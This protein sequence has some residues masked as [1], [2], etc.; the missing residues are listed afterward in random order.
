MYTEQADV[1]D[2]VVPSDR[3][4]QYGSFGVKGRE[5][6]SVPCYVQPAVPKLSGADGGPA[7]VAMVLSSR[8]SRVEPTVYD[9]QEF[10]SSYIRSAAP[11]MNGP[12]SGEDL[13][14]LLEH[15]GVPSSKISQI[16]Q[17]EA[18]NPQAQ[19]TDMA[20]AIR[21]GSPVIAVVDGADLP[22]GGKGERSYTAHWLVVVGFGLG[23]GNQTEVL[24]N[25]PDGTRGYG[26]IKGQPVALET[27]GKAVMDA[28][29]L[30]S[31]QQEPQHISGIVV[32]AR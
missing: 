6:L 8:P 27:F 5:L 16:S 29:I 11:N 21:Q 14:Y 22:T 17:D 32:T 12:I 3:A 31:V 24:V 26:G 10:L 1:A 2:R 25:D 18:G 20:I 9:V 7:S 15:Y 4:G 19:L 28:S 30:P 13:E 23:S